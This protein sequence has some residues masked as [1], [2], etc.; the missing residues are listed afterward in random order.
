MG[1][2][3]DN[4]AELAEAICAEQVVRFQYQKHS[5]DAPLQRIFSPWELTDNG[6]SVLGWDHGREGIR[7]FFLSDIVGEVEVDLTE[8]YAVPVAP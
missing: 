5:D 4:A 6:G 1:Y 7:R 3:N 8:R 2:P